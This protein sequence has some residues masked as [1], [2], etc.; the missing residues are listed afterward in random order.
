MWGKFLAVFALSAIAAN[1]GLAQESNASIW[2]LN[3]ELS[4]ACGRA[5]GHISPDALIERDLTGDGRD[6]LIISH[7]GISCNSGGRSIYCGMQVCTV[8]IFVR[9][10]ELLKLTMDFL[11]GGVHVGHG[12]LPKISGYAHGGSGWSRRWD[13]LQFSK[14]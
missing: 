13:G 9:E 10:G 8:K 14:E 6:D 12:N 11:A 2:L 3:Q 5:G 7:E 1:G 4:E